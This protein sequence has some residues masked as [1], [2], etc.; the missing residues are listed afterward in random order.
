MHKT[1]DYVQYAIQQ[2]TPPR[3]KVTLKIKTKTGNDKLFT[4]VN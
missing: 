4:L 2:L 1:F 3:Y